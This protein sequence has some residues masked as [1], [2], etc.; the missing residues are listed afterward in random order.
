MSAAKGAVEEKYDLARVL[1]NDLSGLIITQRWRPS[2]LSSY[3][4]F[5]IYGG[6][7][8]ELCPVE[9]LPLSNRLLLS[10]FAG[11]VFFLGFLQVLKF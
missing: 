5:I 4:D 7:V 9:L 3:D 1:G 6:G 11:I 8:K 2:L 10:T